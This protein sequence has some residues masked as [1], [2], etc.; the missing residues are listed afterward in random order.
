MPRQFSSDLPERPEGE[1][2]P[3][4]PLA[5]IS[6]TLDGEEFRC[7]GPGNAW[8]MSELARQA[9]AGDGLATLSLMAQSM[10]EALGPAEYQ[11]MQEH[12]EEHKTP[13]ETLTAIMEYV[14]EEALALAEADAGRPTG[15]RGRS[16]TGRPP[17]AR[18][19]SRVIS[20]QRGTVIISEEGEEGLPPRMPQD[21]RAPGGKQRPGRTGQKGRASAATG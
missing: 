19:M 9:A 13:D 21:H 1:E 15:P 14:N 18:Q 10:Y 11:R 6:F 12:I 20:L 16:S 8:H 2:Q 17:R 7:L 3:L 5:S 4:P